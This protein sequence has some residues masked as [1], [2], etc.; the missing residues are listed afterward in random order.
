MDLISNYPNTPLVMG[1]ER[2]DFFVGPVSRG[3]NSPYSN[4]VGVGVDINCY[5][6]TRTATAISG[7]GIGIT[8]WDYFQGGESVPLTI[9]T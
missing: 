8:S 6:I 4:Y 9:F 7:Q 5:Q 3:F 2:R 1:K